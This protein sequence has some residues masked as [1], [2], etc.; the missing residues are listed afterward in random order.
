MS[1]TSRRWF[2]TIPILLILWFLL[3]YNIAA[4]YFNMRDTAQIWV[5]AAVRNLREYDYD[6]IGLMI[7]STPYQVDDISNVHFYSHH[8]PLIVWLPALVAQ[9][10]GENPL[11]LRFIF[12]V[13]TMIAAAAF[14]SL[15]RQLYD[16]KVA[17]WAT[18]FFAISPMNS[19]WQA[20][21]AHDSLGFVPIMLFALIFL[22]WLRKAQ[23]KFF[24]GLILMAILAAWT[25][26]PALF[27]VGVIGI[28]GMILGNWKHRVGVVILGLISI[29]SIFVML[30]LFQSWWSGS[31]NDLINA[32]FW[33]TSSASFTEGTESF[34]IIQWILLFLHHM[35]YHGT[36]SVMVLCIIGIRYLHRNGSKFA[37]GFTYALLLS[38][39]LYLG[40]FR[41]AG[42]L[43]PYYKAF[44][45]PAL[46]IF[47]AMAV[48]YWPK[49]RNRFRSP[50]VSGLILAFV[51]QTIM[52]FN[53]MYAVPFQK[54]IE[55]VIA[56][57]NNTPDLPETI[58]Y[59]HPNGFYNT[60]EMLGFYTNRKIGFNIL[61]DELPDT[62]E[63]ILYIVCY[64]NQN[65]MQDHFDVLP[66]HTVIDDECTAYFLDSA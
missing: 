9:F 7:V 24:V 40:V 46:A 13:A 17:F 27:F 23:F 57:I 8:P 14:Y 59:V 35:L 26:W 41:N 10:A 16:E 66:P 47:A 4:P 31:I 38:G 60:G 3:I 1:Q 6:Q 5:P 18:I 51:I 44:L 15:V 52:V 30:L 28:Y 29:V 49:T 62:Q 65:Y 50:V 12:P 39:A 34:T 32:F 20:A 48:V 22:Y 42:Y 64:K 2:Y 19:Y 54:D 36:I 11:A 33:R 43:H 45:M 37:N 53:F 56:Y 58:Y 61:L 21:F 63:E 55:D 25:A